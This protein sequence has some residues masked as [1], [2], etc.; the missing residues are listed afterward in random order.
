M[1]LIHEIIPVLSLFF[2]PFCRRKIMAGKAV[3]VVASL[4]EQLL[5]IQHQLAD[6]SQLA[7]TLPD[8]P[9]LKKTKDQLL[10]ALHHIISA[11]FAC[12]SIQGPVAEPVNKIHEPCEAINVWRC[13]GGSNTKQQRTPCAAGWVKRN[14][15]QQVPTSTSTPIES[16]GSVLEISPPDAS[17]PPTRRGSPIALHRRIKPTRLFT[18]SASSGLPSPIQGAF[19]ATSLTPLQVRNIPLPPTPGAPRKKA[20]SPQ[21]KMYSAISSRLRHHAVTQIGRGEMNLLNEDNLS[22]SQ[23]SNTACSYPGTSIIF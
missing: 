5:D 12:A 15:P 21:N 18:P 20:A 17:R 22:D 13:S 16:S 10:M 3:S 11:I 1:M 6:V 4:N 2:S 7:D 9:L 19:S 23:Y 8:F 14:S